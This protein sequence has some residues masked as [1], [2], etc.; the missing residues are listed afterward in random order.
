MQIYKDLA[1]SENGLIFN[2]HNGESFQTNQSGIEILKMLQKNIDTV[3]IIE[4]LVQ[5]YDEEQ[6]TIE[7]DFYDFI[8]CLNRYMLIDENNTNQKQSNSSLYKH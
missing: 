7:K 4:V 5:K 1:I 3:D 6:K 8:I 2:P